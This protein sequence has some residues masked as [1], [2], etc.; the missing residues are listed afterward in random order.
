MSDIAAMFGIVIE[1]ESKPSPKKK[2]V[3]QKTDVAALFGIEIEESQPKPTNESI[4]TDKTSSNDISDILAKLG[5]TKLKSV[6]KESR[7]VMEPPTS[8]QTDDVLDANA[9]RITEIVKALLQIEYPPQRSPKWFEMREGSIT[10]SDSGCVLGDNSHEPPYKIFVKK[11]LKPPFEASMFCYHG[12]KLE[13]I[14][15]MVYEFRYNV[16]IEEFGLVKHPKYGFLAA[17]PDGIVGQ[18]KLDGKTKTSN[19]GKM[20]EIK[21]PA[22]RKIRDSDPFYNIKYYWDQVQLQLECCDLE[23][24]DFWQNTITEYKTREDFIADTDESQTFKSSSTGMEKGCLIQLLPKDK[25]T[26]LLDD[27]ENIICGFS[28]F[29]YPPKIDMSP[30]ECDIWIATALNNLEKTLITEVMKKHETMHENIQNSISK[31]DYADFLQ[32]MHKELD[33]CIQKAYHDNEWKFRGKPE[34]YVN[35][36]KKTIR[37]DATRDFYNEYM[38]LYPRKLM[39]PLKNETFIR[40]LVI[41]NVNPKKYPTTTGDEDLLTKMLNL[42]DHPEFFKKIDVKPELRFIKKLCELLK[43][44]EFPKN[45]TFDRVFYW[46]FEKTLCTNVKRDR[47]WFAEKLP[48]FEQTWK[49]IEFMREYPDEAKKIFEYIDGLPTVDENHGHPLKD[50]K[51][52]MDFIRTRARAAS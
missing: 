41:S 33:V 38:D 52:V 44:L 35:K 43:D 23:E 12:T 16:R 24:C 49:Y 13:Q 11:I 3:E 15:T 46:R 9:L 31:N 14:A 2:P 39:E 32:Y 5:K 1:G 6:S 36:V 8:D 27:Y 37:E 22:I 30:I 51:L 10:A 29:L 34:G 45:Y 17:S 18:Y 47:K 4:C 48:I 21:C 50:N 19:V 28:K 26:M 42:N 20:L 25:M 7:H 40:Y